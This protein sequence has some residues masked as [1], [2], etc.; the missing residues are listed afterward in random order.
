MQSLSGHASIAL[1]QL[2]KLLQFLVV[3]LHLEIIR[4]LQYYKYNIGFHI[5]MLSLNDVVKCISL[6]M[7]NQDNSLYSAHGTIIRDLC[8]ARDN[9][10]Q[11]PH[12]LSYTEI[13]MLIENLCNALHAL[14]FSFLGVHYFSFFF[15]VE[16][17]CN[18]ILQIF[19]VDFVSYCIICSIIC[20]I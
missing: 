4:L 19:F 15:C 13:V 14:L 18:F 3:I 8:L 6:Y 7:F 9:H 17:H 11:S 1:I 5:W 16:L 12:M 2:L 20:N 10:Y